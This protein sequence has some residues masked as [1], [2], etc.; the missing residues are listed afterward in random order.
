MPPK[1]NGL[2]SRKMS[3]SKNPH[4]AFTNVLSELKSRK[5]SVESTYS[6]TKVLD[7]INNFITE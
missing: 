7:F 2:P 5:S 1:E 3:P 4:S 6:V